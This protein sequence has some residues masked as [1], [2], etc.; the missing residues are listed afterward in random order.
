MSWR[1]RYNIIIDQLRNHNFDWATQDDCLIGLTA[2]V[3][4]AI[5]EREFFTKYVGRYTSAIG[6]VKVMKNDGFDNLADLVASELEEIHPSECMLGD[7]VA[8]PSADKFGFSIGICNGDRAFVKHEFG[9]GTR[10]MIE[11]TRAFR[12]KQ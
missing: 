1:T 10:S 2:P 3:L 4:Q 8:I 11:V 12:V 5:H 6:A 9:L 7:V